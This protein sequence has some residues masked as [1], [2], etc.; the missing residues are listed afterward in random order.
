[1]GKLPCIEI[2]QVCSMDECVHYWLC[3]YF[4]LLCIHL[5]SVTAFGRMMIEQSQQLVENKYNIANGYS[6]DAKVYNTCPFQSM[7]PLK[8]R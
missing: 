3:I 6:Y 7:C 4:I 5:Q 2:S 8:I 1:M